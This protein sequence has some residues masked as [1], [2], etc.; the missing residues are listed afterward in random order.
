MKLQEVYEYMLTHYGS[1]EQALKAVIYHNLDSYDKMKEAA[2][3]EASHEELEGH[4]LMVITMSALELGWDIA[5]ES[6]QPH[7]RG[8]TMGTPAYLDSIFGPGG[9]VVYEPEKDLEL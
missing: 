5:V 6:G 7:V 3:A 9:D 1:A 8:L 4:P 2:K